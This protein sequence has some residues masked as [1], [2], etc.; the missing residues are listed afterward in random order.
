MTECENWKKQGYSARVILS[1]LVEI[2]E[3]CEYPQSVIVDLE[4]AR[5]QLPKGLY[6][7]ERKLN[8]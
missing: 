7:K 3:E 1:L 8:E 2:L 4:Y 5:N 6:C